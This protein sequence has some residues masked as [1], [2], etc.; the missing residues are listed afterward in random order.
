MTT[1]VFVRAF[2]IDSI[3]TDNTTNNRLYVGGKNYGNDEQH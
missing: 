2:A 1:A 3:E